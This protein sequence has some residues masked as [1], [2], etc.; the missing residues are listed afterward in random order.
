MRNH[1]FLKI[2]ATSEGAISPNVLD[3]MYQPFVNRSL[4]FVTKSV[5]KSKLISHHSR[6]TRT[7]NTNLQS[8]AN[9]VSELF[10]LM[11]GCTMF[12]LPWLIVPEQVIAYCIRRDFQEDSM[13]K[14]PVKP[15]CFS[16]DYEQ[17]SILLTQIWLWLWSKCVQS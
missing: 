10:W 7:C 16:T 5:F 1:L 12:F 9:L 8:F 17:N 6:T 3:Y 2:Y 4:M 13:S 11:I 14:L 15:Q